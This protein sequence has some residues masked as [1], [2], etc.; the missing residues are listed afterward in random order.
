M[1]MAT[2]LGRNLF[3][4]NFAKDVFPRFK[5]PLLHSLMRNFISEM[6]LEEVK[7]EE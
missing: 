1:N 7:K 5:L 6:V 3:R 2:A 4:D